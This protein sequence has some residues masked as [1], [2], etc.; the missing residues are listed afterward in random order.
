M[1]PASLARPA[2]KL[3]LVLPL[4][5]G[6]VTSA[7]REGVDISHDAASCFVA[8]EHPK[9]SA[10]LTPFDRVAR[11][12]TVFRAEGAPHWYS[13]NMPVQREVS[14]AVLPRP[15]K[16]IGHVNYYIEVIDKDL[17]AT[18]TAEYAPVVVEAPGECPS[19]SV[20]ATVPTAALSLGHGPGTPP[21]PT[22]FEAAGIVPGPVGTEPATAV[23]GAA[24][25]GTVK[26]LLI[27]AGVA[28][29]G[30]AVAVASRGG[31]GAG[32][33]SGPTA[34][35]PSPAP[36]STPSP[37]PVLWSVYL[38][39]P[40]NGLDVSACGA[41]VPGGLCGQG[42]NVDSSGAFREIWSP[43]TPVVRVEGVM[44]AT[45][46]SATLTCTATSGSGAMAATRSGEE[47]SGTATLS[48]V[49]VPVRIARGSGPCS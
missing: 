38:G 5:A 23:A 10:Q 12:R 7:G 9:L 2:W 49:T 13:V 43:A 16:G 27:G 20:A 22:G 26:V 15:K 41:N 21:V 45:T 31:G 47:Y 32:S 17:G 28:A 8:G 37:A 11:A 4:A 44:T 33:N 34:A 36:A 35:T 3:L 42:L 19:R 24:G 39:S 14:L 25:G 30:G 29:A 18:R 6:P 46:V 48:G 1:S 40:G